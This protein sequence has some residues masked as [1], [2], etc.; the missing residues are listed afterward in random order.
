MKTKLT[1]GGSLLF[2]LSLA[3]LL[4]IYLSWLVY[5][6]EISWLN[7]TSRVHVQ[8]QTIYHNFNVLM[9]LFDQSIE[10]SISNARFSF[11]CLW[12]SPLCGCKGTL[13][14]SARSS[15][16]YITL[17]LHFLEPGC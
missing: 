11:V 8:P 5:P 10:S 9:N 1:F 16:C 4:T 3:I 14:P 6:L 17:F 13:S 7:L 2:L 12:N 15:S